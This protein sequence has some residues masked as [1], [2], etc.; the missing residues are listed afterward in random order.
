VPRAGFGVI[1]I[2]FDEKFVTC[3]CS[4]DYGAEC[5]EEC[6]EEYGSGY[7]E[8]CN[9]SESVQTLEIAHLN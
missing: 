2:I 4:G 6:N 8:E 9:Q 5:N 1:P 3:E 7:G